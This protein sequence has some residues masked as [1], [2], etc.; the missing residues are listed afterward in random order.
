MR[1]CP[2]TAA[3]TP[4]YIGLRTY[5]YSPDTT[6]CCVGATGAGVPNPLS[7]KRQKDSTTT[8]APATSR[9]Y[10]SQRP[11]GSP[12]G[13]A[14][15]RQR[16]STHGRYPATVAGAIQKNTNEPMSALTR[17][18]TGSSVSYCAPHVR[19]ARHEGCD[20]GV[21]GMLLAAKHSPG[22]LDDPP[23]PRLSWPPLAVILAVAVLPRSWRGAGGRRRRTLAILPREHDRVVVT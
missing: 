16:V 6:R 20:Q 8:A 10:P 2:R 17:L 11:A 1:A 3:R 13:G 9:R 4:R 15:T 21:V 22:A 14:S 19:T 12:S 7:A 18:S 23:R 5:R